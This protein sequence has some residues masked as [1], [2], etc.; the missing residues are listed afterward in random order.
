ML[1]RCTNIMPIQ[2]G[3]LS[4]A[5]T[6][7]SFAPS[8][9]YTS[10]AMSFPTL[11]LFQK[12][13]LTPGFLPISRRSLRNLENMEVMP[14]FLS[15]QSELTFPSIC[16]DGGRRRDNLGGTGGERGK[17]D[18]HFPEN[19]HNWSGKRCVCSFSHRFPGR[20]GW[21]LKFGTREKSPVWFHTKL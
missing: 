18:S 16:L 13:Q 7:V 1:N 15:K 4:Q 19:A 2:E 6:A 10:S 3:P 20:A 12:L 8:F 9:S 5:A 17:G 14:S 11:C 21:N